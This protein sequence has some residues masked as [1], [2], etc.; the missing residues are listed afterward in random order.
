MLYFSFDLLSRPKK[1]FISAK[2]PCNP[3]Y[4]D[5]VLTHIRETNSRITVYHIK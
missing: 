2:Y 3:R 1:R 5:I 4:M